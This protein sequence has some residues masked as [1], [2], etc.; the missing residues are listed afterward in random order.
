MSINITLDPAKHSAGL[1]GKELTGAYIEDK[2]P[3][4][5]FGENKVNTFNEL[6]LACHK[7]ALEKGFYEGSFSLMEKLMLIISEIG[8][9]LEADRCN[10]HAILDTFNQ[11]VQ[12][13]N[14]SDEAWM[15]MFESYIKNSYEDELADIFI[16]LADLAAYKK[17]Y[18]L[19][20]RKFQA[21]RSLYRELKVSERLFILTKDV[22]KIH[23]SNLF[24]ELQQ[25]FT[26]AF[27]DIFSI[28]GLQNIPLGVYI[29]LKMKYNSMRSYKHGKEY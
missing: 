21:N 3:Y 25:N 27:G 11:G 1:Q 18:M 7:N 12:Q 6:I 26:R 19:T 22:A 20:G 9:A 15:E 16:R 29:D 13:P 4:E 10:N 2:S 14:V 8:E 24:I 5:F 23:Q 28:A 17:I